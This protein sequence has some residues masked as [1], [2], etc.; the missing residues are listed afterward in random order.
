MKN[1]P[2]LLA[3][4]FSMMLVAGCSQKNIGPAPLE[5]TGVIQEQ[6][7]TF[8]QYGTHTIEGYAL[9]SSTIDL[10]DYIGQRVTIQGRLVEG[11]P[12][13][14]GPELLEVIKVK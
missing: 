6:G 11:Y 12:L 4:L 3:L 2:I 7:I 9:R 8:Y 14:G 1:L 5:V 13:E 10:N